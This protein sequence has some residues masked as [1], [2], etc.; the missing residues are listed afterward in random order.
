MH[1]LRNCL[2]TFVVILLYLH[3]CLD[4][5]FVL[6]CS[7]V[8]L[9]ELFNEGTERMVVI[10]L[11]NSFYGALR[12]HIIIILREIHFFVHYQLTYLLDF[13]LELIFFPPKMVILNSDLYSGKVLKFERFNNTLMNHVVQSFQVIWVCVYCLISIIFGTIKFS[14]N[15]VH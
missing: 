1:F 12:S 9:E 4:N 10:D 6:N 11:E 8:I 5:Y 14:S 7:S 15:I 3:E 2:L 13:Y